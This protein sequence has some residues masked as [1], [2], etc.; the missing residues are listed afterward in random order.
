MRTLKQSQQIVRFYE[1]TRIWYK[2]HSKQLVEDYTEEMNNRTEEHQMDF[3]EYCLAVLY[4]MFQTGPVKRETDGLFMEE[5]KNLLHYYQNNHEKIKSSY[6][7]DSD[8]SLFD[9]VL[10]SYDQH[11]AEEWGGTSISSLNK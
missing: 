1:T 4:F 6:N 7:T 5:S 9:W 8:D 11:K 10:R 2:E 3:E